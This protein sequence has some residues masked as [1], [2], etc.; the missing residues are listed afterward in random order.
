[1]SYS[2]KS[3]MAI[4]QGETSECSICL[5]NLVPR[6]FGGDCDRA[7][8]KDGEF[9]KDVEYMNWMNW[10]GWNYLEMVMWWKYNRRGGGDPLQNWHSDTEEPGALV[11]SLPCSASV[12]LRQFFQFFVKFRNWSRVGLQVWQ[13]HVWKL[14]LQV[15]CS[16]SSA[17]LGGCCKQLAWIALAAPFAEPRWKTSSC[18]ERNFQIAFAKDIVSTS[19][20]NYFVWLCLQAMVRIY[21]TYQQPFYSPNTEI[22]DGTTKVITHQGQRQLRHQSCKDGMVRD[23]GKL[24]KSCLKGR[25][26]RDGPDSGCFKS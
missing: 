20:F 22:R 5:A 18:W 13:L 7:S 21:I 14:S 19:L 16:T 10:N 1:M 11:S 3:W 9:I 15:I 8:K 12:K 25:R 23:G 17:S 4:V 2:G 26:T 24:S 6:L